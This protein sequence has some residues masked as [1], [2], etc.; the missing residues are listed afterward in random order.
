MNKS[1]TF[2]LTSLLMVLGLSACDS[3]TQT[4]SVESST[5][6]PEHSMTDQAETAST[7][8]AMPATLADILA[9]Q[10]DDVVAR[11][12]YRNPE[13]TL[14]FFG[15]EPGMTVVEA[16]PGGGWY[17]KLLLPYLGSDGELIGANYPVS[18][19]ELFGWSEERLAKA[20]SWTTDWPITA[21]GWVEGDTANVSAFVLGDLAEEQKGTADAVLLIRALHNL[22]RFEADHGHLSAALGNVFDVLKP[23]G[24]VGVVQHAAPDSADDAW[25]NGSRGYLKQAFVIEQMQAAGFEYVS[26][27]DINANPQDLP[28]AED[29]VWRLP[30]TLAGSKDDAERAA[31]MQAIGES[32][33]MTLK[34][35]KPTA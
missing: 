25:A 9:A 2:L 13:Q 33:R 29:S 24:I 19:Y 30:P 5:G 11:Y 20:A 22:A 1:V 12:A 21:K 7:E 34:F 31:A 10:P 16:L 26:A 32:N 15:I 23:G 27:S 8:A 6:A 35:M 4:S 17:S 28:G 18:M 3:S 14:N